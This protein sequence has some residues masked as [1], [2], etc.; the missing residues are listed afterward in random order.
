MI[1]LA[2]DIVAFCV[3]GAAAVA[4]F[5]IVASICGAFSE[6]LGAVPGRRTRARWLIGTVITAGVLLIW[7]AAS[8]AGLA[9][10]A[11]LTGALAALVGLAVGILLIKDRWPVVGVVLTWATWW[12]FLLGLLA[13]VL[14]A[15]GWL[16]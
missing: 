6:W 4:A 16:P 1:D 3:I 13:V 5:A 9:T 10:V 7:H 12:G 11:A 15:K 8:P 2:L 14:R